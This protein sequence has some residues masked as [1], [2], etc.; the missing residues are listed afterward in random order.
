M[1]IWHGMEN[2]GLPARLK[3]LRMFPYFFSLPPADRRPKTVDPLPVIECLRAFTVTVDRYYIDPTP[4]NL[5][6]I[7]NKGGPTKLLALLVEAHVSS[8]AS[9]DGDG[10][11]PAKRK[12][13]QPAS[14]KSSWSGISAAMELYM[15]SV[16][17]M[18]DG[19][20]PLECRLLYRILLIMK[21]DITQYHYYLS[22]EQGRLGQSIWFWKVFVGALAL[23]KSQY[24]HR[25]LGMKCVDC[26]GKKK[27][28]KLYE[29]FCDRARAWSI[30]TGMTKWLDVEAVL[31]SVTW[32]VALPR[33]END[34]A[35]STWD[36][37]ITRYTQ[38]RY[39]P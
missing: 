11:S 28:E 30:A 37:I 4:H 39:R 20:E 35:A 12:I 18:T 15:L 10:R 1:K 14:P 25:V 26:P 7:W 38:T 36:T 33:G 16:L 24:H 34:H 5:N 3:A 31:V 8:F 19:G 6:E 2:G 22:G 21:Q 32:P 27:M 23:A 9:D 17:S 29:W 13:S